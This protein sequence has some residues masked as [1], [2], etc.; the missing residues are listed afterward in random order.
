MQ[1]CVSVVD[2]VKGFPTSID[3]QKIGVDTAANEPLLK[4]WG[5]LKK[6]KLLFVNRLYH[7]KLTM[8]CLI[9]DLRKFSVLP[10]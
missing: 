4:I 9:F 5:R 8:S 3:L 10:I 1:K 7:D 6:F 2:L